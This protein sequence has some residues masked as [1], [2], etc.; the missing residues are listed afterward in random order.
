MASVEFG[1][2]VLVAVQCRNRQLN[3]IMG[4]IPRADQ[5]TRSVSIIRADGKSR[6]TALSAIEGS[7]L[8]R[9]SNAADARFLR[10]GGRTTVASLPRDPRPF[11]MALELPSRSAAVADVLTS[12]GHSLTDDRDDLRDV[13][14][15]L[16]RLPRI[17][18]PELSRAYTAVRVELSCLVADG[19]LTACRSDRETPAAPEVG[20]ATAQ[21]AN[22]LRLS[23]K[24]QAEAEGGVVEIVVTGNRV[25]R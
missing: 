16:I 6:Q 8:F 4:G 25:R 11:Q 17:E 22:G 21:R 2:G 1:E 20:V 7:A 3:I 19:R 18:M 14:D 24:D 5:P 12:C 15:L 13:S 9:S 10:A 23:L